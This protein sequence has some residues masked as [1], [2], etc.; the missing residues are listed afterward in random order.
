MGSTQK[1]G[2]PI[3]NLK[4]NYGYDVNRNSGFYKSAW[5]RFRDWIKDYSVQFLSGST[6]AVAAA[7]IVYVLK[8]PSSH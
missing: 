8:I 1:N 3:Y 6:G 5:E 4:R 7:I 2:S